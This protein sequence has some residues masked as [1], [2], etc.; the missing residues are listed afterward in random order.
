MKNSLQ[1]HGWT[2]KQTDNQEF[3]G[4]HLLIHKNA[5]SKIQ[6]NF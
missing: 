5:T 2:H 1:T 3:T 6:K 4:P